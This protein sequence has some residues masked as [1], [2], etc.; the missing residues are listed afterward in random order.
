MSIYELWLVRSGEL[1][2]YVSGM[3]S[4]AEIIRAMDEISDTVL[5]PSLPQCVC[6]F[7]LRHIVRERESVFRKHPKVYQTFERVGIESKSVKRVLRV[8]A[9][10]RIEGLCD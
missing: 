7:E 8:G 1:V 5:P 2:N 3:P 4:S 6:R 10:G 9:K